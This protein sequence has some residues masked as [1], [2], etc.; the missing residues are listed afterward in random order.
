MDTWGVPKILS[1][2]P[3]CQNHFHSI[4]KIS[5]V[6]FHGMDTFTDGAK[7]MV[8]KTAGALIWIKTGVP[9]CK[10]LFFHHHTPVVKTKKKIV[11]FLIS[12]LLFNT[13]LLRVACDETAGR[14]RALLL[15]AKVGRVSWGTA[16]VSLNQE[17]NQ[18]L[19]SWG[20]NFNPKNDQ[21]TNDSSLGLGI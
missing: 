7:P 16:R 12:A 15:H 21:Q 5:F 4:F 8:H 11:V 6:F 18:P 1:E 17:T 19:S 14:P 2:D 9:N 10:G 20:C 3:Q 13:H